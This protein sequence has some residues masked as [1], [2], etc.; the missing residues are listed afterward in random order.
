MNGEQKG[1]PPD[2]KK[3]STK[4]ERAAWRKKHGR[5]RLLVQIAA[6]AAAAALLAGLV[7]GICGS[8]GRKN[9]PEAAQPVILDTSPGGAIR[10]DSAG[11]VTFDVPEEGCFAGFRL[12]PLPAA[13]S[14][15]AVSRLEEELL[16]FYPDCRECFP[17]VY[18]EI[19][20]VREETSLLELDIRI[21][22][23]AKL[24]SAFPLPAST[25]VVKKGALGAF[26]GLWLTGTDG[27]RT[28]VL[29]GREQTWT[30]PEMNLLL[31]YSASCNCAVALTG[32]A[33]LTDFA[34]LEDTASRLELVKTAFPAL[35]TEGGD[36]FTGAVG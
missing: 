15:A 5:K 14:K 17:G 4:E 9:E 32:S 11:R 10:V 25:R 22:N 16:Q 7:A 23:C 19:Q 3:I 8:C 21:Y 26:E 33:E 6:C 18:T 28:V 27:S 20:L 30:A 12:S 1:L 36:E 34:K 31:L 24:R 29:D 2:G 13:E 35:S